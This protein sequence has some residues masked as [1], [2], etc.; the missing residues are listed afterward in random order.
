MELCLPCTNPSVYKFIPGHHC[1][2]KDNLIT[3]GTADNRF[4]WNK[5]GTF[6]AF[7]S[8]TCN[9]NSR[10]STIRRGNNLVGSVALAAQMEQPW[11]SCIAI[12]AM[13]TR[14]IIELNCFDR[15]YGVHEGMVGSHYNTV[16]FL[17]ITNNNTQ[18]L[19][20]TMWHGNLM[21]LS[22]KVT[23]LSKKD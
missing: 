3:S 6:Y 20:N 15:L 11:L 9:C 17:Q 12:M 14:I 7:M 8:V 10:Q 4:C 16:S 5:A 1:K 23:N 22:E 18:W 21:I 19:W 13:I 2:I